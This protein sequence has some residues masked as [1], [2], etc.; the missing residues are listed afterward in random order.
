MLVLCISYFGLSFYCLFF[1]FL[2][3]ILGLVNYHLGLI[4]HPFFIMNYRA[5]AFTSV[6]CFVVQHTLSLLPSHVFE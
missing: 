3:A 4:V 6:S 2:F 5:I 1:S